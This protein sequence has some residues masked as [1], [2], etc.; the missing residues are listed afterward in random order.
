MATVSYGEYH[1]PSRLLR[2]A[3]AGH[4]AF[5]PES[6]QH[7]SYLWEGRSSPLGLT[8]DERPQAELTVAESAVLIGFTDGLIE[9]RGESLDVGLARLAELA[10]GVHR[11][12][13]LNDWCDSTI[14]NLVDTNASDDTALLCIRF[15]DSSPA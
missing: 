15:D 9:R 6:G 14:A 8:S 3:S 10:A 12:I 1:P 5:M 7:T 13:D 4:M 2:Y 11:H